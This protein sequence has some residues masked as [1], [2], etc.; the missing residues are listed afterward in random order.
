MGLTCPR[1]RQQLFHRWERSGVFQQTRIYLGVG[2]AIAPDEILACS[3]RRRGEKL[4]QDEQQQSGRKVQRAGLRFD[5][6]IHWVTGACY[7]AHASPSCV[8]RHAK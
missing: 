7:F 3:D 5:F 1:H 6:S 2:G 4:Q 8:R